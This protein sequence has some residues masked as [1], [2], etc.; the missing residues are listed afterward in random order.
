MSDNTDTKPTL[1]E[2]IKELPKTLK[3]FWKTPPKGR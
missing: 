1:K 3:V 2:K